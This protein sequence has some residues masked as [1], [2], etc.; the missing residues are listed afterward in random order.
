[1]SVYRGRRIEAKPLSNV[2]IYLDVEG[3]A[4]GSLPATFEVIPQ[5]L[6]VRC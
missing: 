6:R 5:A 3:E 2:P 4:P 1:V